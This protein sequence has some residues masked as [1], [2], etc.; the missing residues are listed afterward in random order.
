MAFIDEIWSLSMN[1][2]VLPVGRKKM[3]V[4][5]LC[6]FKKESLFILEA[7]NE[8]QYFLHLV[9]KISYEKK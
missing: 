8:M 9:K 4:G 2:A 5:R 7:R 6:A 3:P 1:F